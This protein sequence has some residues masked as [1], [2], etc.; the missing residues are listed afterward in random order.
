MRLRPTVFKNGTE[1]W[2]NKYKGKL[3]S[4]CQI[5]KKAENETY[6]ELA[7]SIKDLLRKAYPDCSEQVGELLLNTFLSNC[8]D[9]DDF[10][11]SVKR[12]RQKNLQDAVTAAIQEECLRQ[13]E[14]EKQTAE[15]NSGLVFHL[16]RF[17][18]R[19]R[20]GNSSWNSRN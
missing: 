13:T 1:I 20:R 16:G 5:E 3:F 2:H 10:T 4:R 18:G 8:H 9:S 11:V 12:T 15:H 17:R 6:R 14:R 7:Q 19:G